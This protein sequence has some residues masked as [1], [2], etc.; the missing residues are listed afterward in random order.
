MPSV[1]RLYPTKELVE[2]EAAF[3]SWIEAEV[4]SADAKYVELTLEGRPPDDVCH[5][6][7]R[8]LDEFVPK[9]REHTE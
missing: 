8:T 5:R 2:D 3:R 4:R 9:Q 6:V 1:L 7:Q